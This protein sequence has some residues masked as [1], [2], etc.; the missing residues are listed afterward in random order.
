[1]RRSCI[2]TRMLY[3]PNSSQLEQQNSW[4]SSCNH[5]YR[6]H[7]WYWSNSQQSQWVWHWSCRL[8]WGNGYGLK[9]WITW[10]MEVQIIVATKAIGMG[11]D[12]ANIWNVIHNGVLENVLSWAQELDRA[13]RIGNKIVQ[14]FCTAEMTF[15]MQMP[16]CST[17]YNA[18]NIAVTFSRDSPIHGGTCRHTFLE[19]AKDECFWT[20]LEKQTLMIYQL[21][22]VVIYAS[23]RQAVTL[24]F[25]TCAKNLQC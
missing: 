14:W 16:V 5:L 12:K 21:G 15:Y 2:K 11:I 1:M 6:L 24:Q 17:T 3:Q 7:N 22:L 10:E 19:Y 20:F 18:K 8:L 9:M 13:G 23:L 25:K 4:N